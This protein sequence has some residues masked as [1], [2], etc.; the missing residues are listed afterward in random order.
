MRT[1]KNKIKT[2]YKQTKSKIKTTD[3]PFPALFSHQP[4][5]G[6]AGVWTMQTCPCASVL[7]SVAAIFFLFF[8][9]FPNVACLFQLDEF[10]DA[11]FFSSCCQ[12]VRSI[13]VNTLQK[14]QQLRPLPHTN[15]PWPSKSRNQKLT[16]RN[17]KLALVFYPRIPIK[18]LHRAA[19]QSK[20][21]DCFVFKICK[22]LIS[23]LQQPK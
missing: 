22:F 21:L 16:S 9:L 5:P 1:K 19:S 10:L 6:V 8:R 4:R 14:N 15:S 2:K 20:C 12:I 3:V 23:Y 17:K 18:N 11:S 7:F 13:M